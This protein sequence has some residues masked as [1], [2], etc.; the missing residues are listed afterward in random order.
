[1]YIQWHRTATYSRTPSLSCCLQHK[2]AFEIQ[3][4][5]N[6][7]RGFHTLTKK[8]FSAIYLSLKSG[9][10]GNFISVFF[11]EIGSVHHQYTAV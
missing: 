5:T 3:I 2:M 10:I 8:I 1:M 7:T 6:R 9:D 4:F 11:L